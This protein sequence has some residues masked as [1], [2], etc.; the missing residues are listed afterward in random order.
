M[1]LTILGGGGFRVPNLC[2]AL[3]TEHVGGSLAAPGWGDVASWWTAAR[4]RARGGDGA[5][6]ELGRRYGFLDD[7][8]QGRPARDVRR[9][10]T[11]P[12][13]AG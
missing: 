3:S 7:V 13:E 8:V 1:R 4:T 6:V 10:A 12:R 5:A 11:T 2:A 9:A